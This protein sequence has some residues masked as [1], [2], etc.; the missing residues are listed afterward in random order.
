[1]QSK[2]GASLWLI[3]MFGVAVFSMHFGASCML[4]PVTW[5]QQSGSSVVPAAL[6]I[7][8][9]AII[10]PFLGYLA[11]VRGEGSFYE[12]ARR[13]NKKFAFIF[14]GLTVAVLDRCS[15]SPG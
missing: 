14:G 2:N 3:I 4:W 15:S 8:I 9:T 10:F 13:I 11:I 6:G 1:M 12:L 5:G 7:I